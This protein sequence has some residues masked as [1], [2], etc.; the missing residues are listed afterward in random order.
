MNGTTVSAIETDA[1]PGT[2]A[3]VVKIKNNY[4]LVRDGTA[5]ISGVTRHRLKDGTET[6]VITVKGCKP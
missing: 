6:H 4:V 2:E 5:Y 3:E 1:Q